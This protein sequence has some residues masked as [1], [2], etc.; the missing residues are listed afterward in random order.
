MG[1]SISLFAILGLLISVSL[2]LAPAFLEKSKSS[3]VA[4]N[5]PLE[6]LSALYMIAAGILIGTLL[7][8]LTL[9]KQRKVLA[10]G[11]MAFMMIFVAYILLARIVPVADQNLQ[12]ALKDF[13]KTAG[14]RLETAGG[15][16]IVYGLNK[17]SIVFYARRPVIVL[18]SNQ[19][20]R[21]NEVITSSKRFYLIT[22]GSDIEGLLSRPDLYLIDQK[23]GYALLSNQPPQ[24]YLTEDAGRRKES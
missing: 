17:P 10:F 11:V 24:A 3:S 22:K 2:F 21:L 23:R 1:F 12:S 4:I 19:R 16:L 14:V 20:E 18:R 9:W 6:G 13:A 8:L 7:S 5:V 15:D